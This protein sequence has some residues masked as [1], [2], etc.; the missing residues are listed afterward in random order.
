MYVISSILEQAQATPISLAPPTSE[1]P[2]T[3]TCSGYF[4]GIGEFSDT[5]TSGGGGGGGKG[6]QDGTADVECTCL[7]YWNT[8]RMFSRN[9][10]S[11]LS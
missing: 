6:K 10:N 9:T 7:R 4:A 8:S 5:I 1:A 11:T 3:S 2:P